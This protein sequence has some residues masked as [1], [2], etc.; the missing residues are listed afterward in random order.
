MKRT[1]HTST[2]AGT[3][4]VS[5]LPILVSALVALGIGDASAALF[6]I[7]GDHELQPNLAGQPLTLHVS[8][9]GTAVHVDTFTLFAAIGGGGPS[10]G[11]PA[12]PVIT[13]ADL[14]TGTAFAPNFSSEVFQ[15]AL[16]SGFALLYVTTAV[17]GS[18]VSILPGVNPLGTVIVDTTGFDVSDGPWTLRLGMD[19]DGLGFVSSEYVLGGSGVAATLLDGTITMAAVPEPSQVALAVGVGLIGLGI[20]RRSRR[21]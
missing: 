8:N 6:L 12:V 21:A 3:V 7:A 14:H 9:T 16:P 15:E 2:S 20:W 5:R 1:P 17:S 4:T 19:I 13:D 18:T 11:G 10:L